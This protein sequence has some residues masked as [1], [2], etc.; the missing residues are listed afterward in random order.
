MLRPLI[1]AC[2]ALLIVESAR[3]AEEANRTRIAKVAELQTVLD[4]TMAS[5]KT[6]GQNAHVALNG[7]ILKVGP[8]CERDDLLESGCLDD[9]TPPPD[10]DAMFPMTGDA[11]GDDLAG[12]P[13]P[14]GSRRAF[15]ATV[16]ETGHAVRIYEAEREQIDAQMTQA[17]WKL[18]VAGEVR[19]YIRDGERV[20]VTTDGAPSGVRI[21]LARVALL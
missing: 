9:G 20:L 3:E 19:L 12:V 1:A 14:A 21:T 11:P 2:A 4:A 5:G 10:L 16:L 17:G 13:R 15:S 6:R 18:A 8:G 7:A